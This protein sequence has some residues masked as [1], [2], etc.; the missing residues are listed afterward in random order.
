MTKGR[1]AAPTH[2]KALRGTLRARDNQNPPQAATGTPAPPDWLSDRASEIFNALCAK[3]LGMGVLSP[4]HV[5][6]LSL[7]ASRIEEV[8]ILTIALEDGGRT[9]QTKTRDGSVM[10]RSRP[11]VGQRN[12][13]MRHAQSLLSD[14]GLN[15]SAMS[16]VTVSK[17]ERENP[18]AALGH[19]T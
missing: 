2:L 14:F 5:D 13:A 6:A 18:F 1:K 11:E 7:L 16:K 10:H 15:P 12:E 9:Y 3:L 4:D 17:P 19:R 8:E